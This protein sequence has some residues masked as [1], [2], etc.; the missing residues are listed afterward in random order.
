MKRVKDKITD[1]LNSLKF[2]ESDKSETG[3]KFVNSKTKHGQ[4]SEIFDAENLG[5]FRPVN[6]QVGSF[7]KTMS[8][9]AFAESGEFDVAHEILS[10]ESKLRTV[11]LVIERETP[12]ANAIEYTVNLCKRIGAIVDVLITTPSGSNSTNSM[13]AQSAGPYAQK[14]L[15]LT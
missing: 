8:A 7:G 15:E 12:N 13:I 9:A 6:Q 10:P 4:L 2:S 5:V 1:I 11:L 14:I 3:T